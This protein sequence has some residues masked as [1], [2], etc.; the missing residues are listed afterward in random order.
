MD[1]DQ[2]CYDK[3]VDLNPDVLL[4]IELD[5]K[6][7]QSM[8][9]LEGVGAVGESNSLVVSPIETFKVL[10]FSPPWTEVVRKGKTRGKS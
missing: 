4:P 1:G 5:L 7:D 3:F 10:E 9:P 6:S 2:V 8:L